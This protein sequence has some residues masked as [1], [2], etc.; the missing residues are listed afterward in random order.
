M[1]LFEF[2]AEKDLSVWKDVDAIR[3]AL[4]RYLLKADPLNNYGFEGKRFA[5]G[6]VFLVLRG[7]QIELQDE[8]ANLWFLFGKEEFGEKKG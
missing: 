1:R 2:T 3:G 5:N 8:Y 6:D 4:I 7:H